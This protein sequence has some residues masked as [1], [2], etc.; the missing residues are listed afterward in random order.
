MNL[1]LSIARFELVYQSRQPTFYVF[2]LLVLGQGIWYP[3]QITNR[4]AYVDPTPTT[5]LTL[6]TM[7]VMLALIAV[8]LAGQSLTKESQYRAS[9]LFVLPI[10]PR[11]HFIGRFVGTYATTLLLAL[12]YPIGMA[13]SPAILANALPTPWIALVDGY[14]R[15]L[16][17]NV[18]IVVSLTFSLTILLRGMQ[19]AYLSLFGIV[20]YF[21]LT[22]STLNLVADSDLWQLLDPFGVSMA[23]ESVEQG[24]FGEHA[25]D[26]L[27]YSDLFLINRLLWLG[28]ALGLLSYAERN[29]VVDVS[30]HE[31]PRE[32]PA[33]H[34][35]GRQQLPG[36]TVPVPVVQPHFGAW[37]AC[38]TLARLARLEWV[39]LI[40]KPVFLL[41]LGLLMVL[42][43]LLLTLLS[44]QTDFP[45][46][47]ITARMTAV[48]LP[49]GLFISVFLLIMTGE[50][51]FQERLTG[52]WPIYD[53]LP[54]PRV[55]LLGAKL[56]ALIGVAALLTGV[57]FLSGIGVQ[58]RA[59]F[60]G[61]DWARYGADLLVDG[62]L[63]YCQLIALG[64]LVATL[65]NNRLVSHVISLLGFALLA[66]GYQLS[67]GEPSWYLYSFLPGSGAYSDLIGYGAN[68]PLRPLVHRLWW[69]VAGVFITYFVLTWNR[70]VVMSLYERRGQWRKR[71]G[72]PYRLA[73]LIFG[74]LIGVSVWQIHQR[75]SFPR[76]T[77]AL[78]Q[79]TSRT[80][81]TLSV[82]GRQITI[83]LRYHHPYQVQP[84]LQAVRTSLQQGERLFGA[85]PYE[86]LR[87]VETPSSS[88]PVLSKPG[89]LLIAENQ[90]W[91]ADYRQPDQLDYIDYLIS[92]EVVNQWL[93]HSLTADQ[94][95]GE[96]SF[97]QGLADYLALQH[98][99]R[100]YGPERLRQRLSQ[101]AAW[102]RQSRKGSFPAKLILA[103]S[104]KNDVLAF[105]RATLAL[106][107]IEQVWGT[108]PLSFTIGQFY[109]KAIHHPGYATLE[110]FAAELSRQ[111]PDSLAYLSAYLKEP[112][113]F[114]FK[115]GRVAKLANGLTVE[116]I[117]V[118]WR[119]VQPG[120]R[121]P[122]PINDYIPVA[123]LDQNGRTL[124]RQLAHPNPDE[125]YVFLPALANGRKVVIDPLGAWPEANKRDN[126]KLF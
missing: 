95:P 81:T 15:L 17:Q 44:P 113:W 48:R 3:I 34:Q 22:D 27:T 5:Y 13:L 109:R 53:A 126:E 115:V 118:K 89:L 35:P 12:C 82:S 76:L 66:S 47:P 20:L 74:C 29:Y 94:P 45:Q 23:R 91:T 42:A 24:A 80:M 90:G 43:V 106:T 16:S 100:Q 105:G 30:G 51:I 69:G 96:S 83:H 19:G 112:L 68:A 18:F 40:R 70:G 28:L 88:P 93:V 123:V 99:S 41:T 26:L 63:R 117:A 2:A 85:Y 64:A 4:Y 87:V 1:L 38:Q 54:Q 72:P 36:L 73:L 55:V 78:P 6:S 37:V 59:G 31:Q 124:Y 101:R 79:Y 104:S 14:L 21:L 50:L 62:F 86:T 46:L 11:V 110:V 71:F 52:F 119:E 39:N 121:Q 58:L 61:I 98:V 114:D 60:Y 120:Q 77:P 8:L 75:R 103:E 97:K 107:S 25:Q 67:A 116:L 49:M 92:R 9:Y 32:I 84:I 56:V 57:L 10:T 102:Y 7:G 65:V 111:L 125:R 122:I 108:K 33:V